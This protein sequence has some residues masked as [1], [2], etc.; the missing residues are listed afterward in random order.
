MTIHRSVH[1]TDDLVDSVLFHSGFDPQKNIRQ[2]YTV[3]KNE[4]SEIQKQAVA[5]GNPLPVT[6][7]VSIAVM[8]VI[9]DYER[10]YLRRQPHP[11]QKIIGL[12]LGDAR[13]IASHGLN[14]SQIF[15]DSDR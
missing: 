5:T 10:L 11:F 1:I 14:N 15:T 3:I 9:S 7:V 13:V 12:A 4:F 2:A 8:Q 6:F